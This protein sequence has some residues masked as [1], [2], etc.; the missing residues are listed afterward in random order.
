[1]SALQDYPL[2]YSEQEAQR[3][4][5]QAALI[6][7]LTEDVL[8]RAGIRSGMRVLDI[9][10]GF[11]DVSMLTARMVG[12]HGTVLG[13][14]KSLSSVQAARRRVADL[15]ISNVHFEAGDLAAFTDD[16]QFDAIV[17]RLVLL[18]LRDPPAALRGLSRN[19]RPGAVV[20]LQEIDMS[21]MS[22]VPASKLFMQLRGWL[23]EAFATGGTELDIGSKLYTTFLQAGLPPPRMVSATPIACGPN[24]SEY[25]STVRV[26][27]SLLP[28]IERSGIASASE[29]GIDTLAARLRD[30]A[31]ANDRVF[32]LGRLV[33]AWA[34]LP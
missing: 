3:L 27:R 1:M 13:I 15:G 10:S 8:R 18:Y 12:P 16:R 28:L 34:H 26:L 22:Q 19:L 11:G 17:G 31:V 6:E 29:T 4:A 20:V 33:G 14:D 23:L 9:G 32:F 5:A 21:E 7:E 24:S 30:D 25:D 2:G